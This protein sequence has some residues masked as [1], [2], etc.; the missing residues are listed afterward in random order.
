MTECNAQN[1]G[2]RF[3]SERNGR[4]F[5]SE[6]ASDI[7]SSAIAD[8]LWVIYEIEND[9]LNYHALFKNSGS[10]ELTV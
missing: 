3:A 10:T 8:F 6:E 9:R 2:S 5:M 4:L 1:R 7:A